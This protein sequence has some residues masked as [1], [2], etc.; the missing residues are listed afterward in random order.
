MAAGPVA[1]VGVVIAALAL[2]SLLVGRHLADPEDAAPAVGVTDRATY[3][4]I[5]RGAAERQVRRVVGSAPREVRRPPLA[6]DDTE[7]WLYDRRSGREGGYRF[8]FRDGV[9]VTKSRD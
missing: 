4:A 1:M 5:G 6:I 8:C 7:C 3:E 9:L 2:V